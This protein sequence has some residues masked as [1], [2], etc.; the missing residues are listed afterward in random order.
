VKPVQW[1]KLAPE[2]GADS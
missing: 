1:A 2:K